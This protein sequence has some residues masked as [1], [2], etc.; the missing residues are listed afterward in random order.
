MAATGPT[1]FSISTQQDDAGRLL[2]AVRGELD[3]ATAPQLEQTLMEAIEEGRDVVLDLRE[4][5][6]MDSSGV[7]VLVVAHSR[8]DGRF[9][10]VPAGPKSPVTK[11]LAI[12]GLEPELR[13]VDAP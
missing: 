11:I 8:A 10:L 6:F 12:A 5:E 2:V 3:L 1:G 7:R 13:F 4:L 9:G